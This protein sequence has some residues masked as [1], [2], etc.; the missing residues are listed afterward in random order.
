MVP[1]LP[2]TLDFGMP[3]QGQHRPISMMDDMGT[4]K[5]RRTSREMTSAD[6]VGPRQPLQDVQPKIKWPAD[7]LPVEIFH[8][9]AKSLSRSNVQAMRLVNK[10]FEEKISTYLFRTVVVPFR[11]EIYG[12][13]GEQSQDGGLDGTY[14]NVM[15]RDKGMRVFQGFGRHILRFAMSF[16][17]D[18]AALRTPPAKSDQEAVTSFWG[19]Y[20][21]PFPK[22]NRFRSL[23]GLE[24]T[25]DETRTMAKALQYITNANE[26]ALSIDGGLGW[27]PGPDC[28]IASS[29]PNSPLPV[30]G[31]SR[32]YDE[33]I[34]SES[35]M[36]EPISFGQALVQKLAAHQTSLKTNTPLAPDMEQAYGRMLAEAGYTGSGVKAALRTMAESEGI[37]RSLKVLPQDE[38]QSPTSMIKRYDSLSISQDLEDSGSLGT[39]DV[40]MGT[41]RA[42]S[43]NGQAGI[44]TRA[45]PTFLL[46]RPDAPNDASTKDTAGNIDTHPLKPNSL[47]NSQK[48]MLLET[49]WAQRAFMQSWTIAVVDNP[50]AFRHITKLTVARLPS[51]HV[52]VLRRSDFWHSLESLESVSLAII[53]DWREM[54]KAAT[55]WVEDTRLSPSQAVTGVY[56]LLEQYVAPKKSIIELHFEW[57]CGGEE[58]S[59]LFARNQLVLPAPIIQKAV[60]MIATSGDA[61]NVL[62]LPYIKTL[63][64][65]NCWSSPQ[66]LL[67]FLANMRM[68]SLKKASLQ[69]VYLSVPVFDSVAIAPGNTGSQ[70][71]AAGLTLTGVVAGTTS[72]AIHGHSASHLSNT[73]SQ[74]LVNNL[75]HLAPQQQSTATFQGPAP[76]INAKC[77]L[78]EPRDW[79]WAYIIDR[80]TPSRT[81]ADERYSRDLGPKP[82]FRRPT[83]LTSLSF[84]SCGYVRLPIDLDQS[85]LDPPLASASEL[86]SLSKRKSDLSQFMMVA[87][88]Q[89]VG[90]IVPHIEDDEVRTLNLAWHLLPG[91]DQSMLDSL[92]PLSMLDGVRE[93]GKGRFRGTVTVA[94]H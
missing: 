83:S 75:T 2:G 4:S 84:V 81:L 26:L 33:A 82:L 7:E 68:Q 77:W 30:F 79:S 43:D 27:L 60:A 80:V 21:W 89:N 85:I 5:R 48:E 10:E 23:E 32:Y 73:L 12:I 1:K 49:E 15:L 29:G 18:H 25:A 86:A 16:E 63:S 46:G 44:A 51:R 64:L 90:T 37:S 69:F 9:I 58:A 31:M 57:L 6:I 3:R 93:P 20:R 14:V 71:G 45:M 52:N 35:T 70:A 41:E 24:Q 65:K 62:S 56:D 39:Y 8:V 42:S 59:G 53:P 61:S 17:I 66:I 87:G 92:G 11:P 74:G 88:D 47:K 78:D 91:W 36:S 54:S 76:P 28:S 50:L 22:Y 94:G 40:L 67:K 34:S 72:S 38:P 13:S 19:I 55:G